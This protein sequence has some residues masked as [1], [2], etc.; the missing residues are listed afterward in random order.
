MNR[1]NEERN[2]YV[3][4][5]LT[6]TLLQLM[7]SKRL[8]DISVSELTEKAGVGRVSF[9]RNY[10]DMKQILEQESDRLLN[11]SAKLP[12]EEGTSSYFNFFDFIREHRDFFT[13]LCKAGLSNIIIESILKTT[14]IRPDSPNLEAYLKSFWAYG[15]YGWIAE[16]I[17]R[18]MKES[19]E[20]MFSLFLAAQQK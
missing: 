1:R 15:L 2:T 20:E 18:G 16:W 9:Y 6:D 17:N 12:K 5:Q 8:E 11:E 7:R 19:S 3:K 4:R 13:T 14:D 10:D